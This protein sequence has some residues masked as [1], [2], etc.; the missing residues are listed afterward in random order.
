[1]KNFIAILLILLGG[2]VPFD[3]TPYIHYF[4]IG[5]SRDTFVN[6]CGRRPDN[7]TV[8]SNGMEVIYYREFVMAYFKDGKLAYWNGQR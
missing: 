6:E 1:M 2:C 5:M 7:D 4:K 3:Q 8:D